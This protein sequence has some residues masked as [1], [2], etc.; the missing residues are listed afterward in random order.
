MNRPR[1]GEGLS[2]V[3]IDMLSPFEDECLD[4]G[5][6]ILAPEEDDP[7]LNSS[8]ESEDAPPQAPTIR[9]FPLL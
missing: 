4:H 2:Q 6:R 1:Q 8:S 5:S 7:F 9:A 3:G